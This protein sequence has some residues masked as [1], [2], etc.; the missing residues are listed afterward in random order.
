MTRD[1]EGWGEERIEETRGTSSIYT[2]PPR[3]PVE[4]VDAFTVTTWLQ[5]VIEATNILD[6]ANGIIDRLLG[7]ALI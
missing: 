4:T 3:G 1:E 5:C 6:L 2:I 7:W